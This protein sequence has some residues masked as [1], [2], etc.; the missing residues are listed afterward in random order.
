MSHAVIYGVIGTDIRSTSTATGLPAADFRLATTHRYRTG[1]DTW[2]NGPTSW[3]TVQSYRRLA[4]NAQSSLKKGDRV[5]VTGRVQVRDWESQGR[6]G[7]DVQ[8]VA[9]S[10]GPDLRYMTCRSQRS[11]NITPPAPQAEAA[12]L[13]EI[14]SHPL[15]EY[16]EDSIDLQTG[17]ILDAG[18]E[19]DDEGL[20]SETQPVPVYAGAEPSTPF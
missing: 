4:Q 8:I 20:P 2:V 3:F 10:I 16:P 13:N 12:D 18:P 1:K 11:E 9:E 17:E 5:I 19:D 15:S 6:H 7:R 14:A